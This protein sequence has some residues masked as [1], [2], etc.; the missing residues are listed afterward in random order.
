MV[1]YVNFRKRRSCLIGAVFMTEFSR[2][3]KVEIKAPVDRRS[4]FKRKELPEIPIYI[5]TSNTGDEL[6][7]KVLVYSLLKNTEHPLKITFLRHKDFSDWCI[8]G[9]GTPFTCLRYAIPELEGFKG[10][11]IYMDVDMINMRDIADLWKTDLEG[12]PFGMVWDALQDNGRNMDRGWWCDSVLIMDC[13]QGKDWFELDEIKNWNNRNGGCFKWEFMSRLGNSKVDL[14]GEYSE[15]SPKSR[16]Y[17]EKF[18]RQL[19]AR[20]NS[21]D[22]TVTSIKPKGYD[23]SNFRGAYWDKEQLKLEEC[24]QIHLTALSYQPWHPRYLKAAKSTHW[25]PDI[26]S[27]WWHYAESVRKIE[28][29]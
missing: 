23:Q 5:G 25:R 4:T 24:F 26:M 18:V 14:R 2:D 13:T 6:A 27:L 3:S 12:K 10:K 1:F 28:Q 29:K 8:K 9:W 19:D 17:S 22:G 11:A 21:F 15:S 16:E 7:E 20:W